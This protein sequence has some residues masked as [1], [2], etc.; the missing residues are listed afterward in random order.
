LRMN[1][2]DFN[3]ACVA[4]GD[5]DRGKRRPWPDWAI[6][7]NVLPV[8]TAEV[9]R[10]HALSWTDTLVAIVVTTI[11]LMTLLMIWKRALR[12]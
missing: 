5:A 8:V 12:G 9:C 10:S 3:K 4:G 1:C 2:G 11:F 7:I 6:P